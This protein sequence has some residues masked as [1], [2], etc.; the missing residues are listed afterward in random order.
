MNERIRCKKER[1]FK[2]SEKKKHMNGKEEKEK[3][4][5][6]CSCPKQTRQSLQR[7]RFR[8]IEVM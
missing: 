6:G 7:K 4:G 5:K 8:K 2:T 3:K 1:K